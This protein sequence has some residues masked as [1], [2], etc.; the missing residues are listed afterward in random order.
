MLAM[1]SEKPALSAGN[2]REGYAD[3]MSLAE[4][5]PDL[6]NKGLVHEGGVFNL[7]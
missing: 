6:F 3:R 1:A 2:F 4:D 5:V 7:R